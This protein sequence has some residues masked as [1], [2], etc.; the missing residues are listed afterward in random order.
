[1]DSFLFLAI[2]TYHNIAI[3]SDNLTG[4]AYEHW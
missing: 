2:P 4:I 1:M 3:K